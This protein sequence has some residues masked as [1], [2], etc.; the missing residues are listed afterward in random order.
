VI[1][2]LRNDRRWR[3]VLA[4]ND[5]A[6]VVAVT[7]APPWHTYEPHTSADSWDPDVD[8]IR[9]INWIQRA[10]GIQLSGKR[11]ADCVLNVAQDRHFHP[12]RDHLNGLHWDSTPRLETFFSS[13]CG[14]TD[15]LYTRAVARVMFVG[16]VARA[17]K[18]GCKHDTVVVLE[19][20]QGIRKSTLLKVLASERYF[21]EA[22]SE[23]GTKDAQLAMHGKWLLEIPELAGLGN[24]QVELIKAFFSRASDWLRPPYAKAHCDLLRSSAPVATT[25]ASQY[26]KD[27][28]GNRR[29]LPIKLGEAG[30]ID[31]DAVVRDRDQLW[32][33]AVMMWRDCVPWWINRDDPVLA[34]AN[35][36][37]EARE[38]VDPWEEQIRNWLSKPTCFAGRVEGR[39]LRSPLDFRRGVSTTDVLTHCLM[40]P[41]ER[42]CDQYAAR[43]GVI[44]RRI[45]MRCV[46][47]YD[48]KAERKAQLRGEKYE[49]RRVYRWPLSERQS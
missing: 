15:N 40:V 20:D 9:L 4:I 44:L 8:P 25:N 21:A 24:A 10:Y 46:R 18:P 42:Q 36:Q 6:K 45:G 49:R 30:P 26:L 33:E 17:M 16:L 22:T 38:T 23:I 12:V 37:V 14:S 27:R 35:R 47:P 31:I 32:A 13:Y 39:E 3:G 29:Y 43:V 19:G 5:M 1:A 11:C 2:I 34:L 48:R 28:T 7:R 41:V